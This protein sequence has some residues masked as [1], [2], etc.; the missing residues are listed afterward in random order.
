MLRRDNEWVENFLK[1][2]KILV[3]LPPKK[4]LETKY[5]NNLVIEYLTT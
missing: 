2:K 1:R 4:I 5:I 3:L